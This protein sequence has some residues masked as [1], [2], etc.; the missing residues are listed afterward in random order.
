VEKS[1]FPP[2]P[3]TSDKTASIQTK[4]QKNKVEKNGKFS[5]PNKHHQLTINSPRSHHKF[6]I[7]KPHAAPGFSQNTP[8]KR[9]QNNK[10]PALTGGLFFS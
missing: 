5:T 1:A 8:Q 4:H 7:K 6:T 2:Q 9:P 10:T 3:R